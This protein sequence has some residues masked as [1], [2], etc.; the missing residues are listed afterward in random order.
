[1]PLDSDWDPAFESPNPQASGE[2]V[3]CVCLVW[4]SLWWGRRG[5]N[6]GVLNFL[7]VLMRQNEKL[8]AYLLHFV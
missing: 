8:P 4:F 3:T 5:E 1:M 7:Y 2:K 6:V